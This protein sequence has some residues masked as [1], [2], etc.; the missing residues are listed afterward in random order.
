[1]TRGQPARPKR[2]PATPRKARTH[3]SVSRPTRRTVAGAHRHGRPAT[4]DGRDKRDRYQ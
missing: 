2:A 1:M 3:V 4:V